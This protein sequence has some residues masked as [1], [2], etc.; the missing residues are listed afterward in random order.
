VHKDPPAGRPLG[1]SEQS[2]ANRGDLIPASRELA[3]TS[4]RLDERAG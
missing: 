2:T 1:S 3:R 4:C